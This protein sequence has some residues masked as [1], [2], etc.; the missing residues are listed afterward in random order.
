MCHDFISTIDT[1]GKALVKG[2]VRKREITGA[3]YAPCEPNGW[4]CVL[5]H[6]G[7]DVSLVSTGAISVKRED[8]HQ[9]IEKDEKGFGMA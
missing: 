1:Q 8:L 2:R 5:L 9:G 3:Q 6:D 4:A 7:S